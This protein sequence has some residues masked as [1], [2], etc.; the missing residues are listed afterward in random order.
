LSVG[1]ILIGALFGT[2]LYGI[3][4]DKLPH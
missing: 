1:L 4:K 3:L 2:F